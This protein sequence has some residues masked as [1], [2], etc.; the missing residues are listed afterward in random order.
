MSV[1]DTA[2]M[3]RA[4]QLAGRGRYS[5]SPNPR[6]ACIIVK[7]GAV[8]AE[9][10]HQRAGEGHAEAL[11]LQQAGTAAK[12]ATAYVTLEPCSH[13][14]RTPPCADALIA[15]GV[16]RVVVAC[17]DPNPR[18]AGTGIQRLLDAGIEVTES[19]L[20]APAQ[21][22]NA[23]FMR[24]IAGGL[25]RVHAKMASS[26]DGR[27]A[28]ASGESQWITG[29]DAR[30]DVQGLRASACAIVTGIDS[31]IQD[32]ARL[33]VRAEALNDGTPKPAGG[34][35]Q[36]LRVV[37]DSQLRLP[38]DCA[39]LQCEGAV[40]VA[41]VS[42]DRDRRQAL[43]SAG[44]EVLLL[45]AGDDGRVDALALLKALAE[46]ECN[47]V[48]LECGPRLMA[49]FFR[50]GLVDA[51]TLY[52]A[53]CFLGASGR[54]LVDFSIDAMADQWQMQIDD[55]RAVGKDWRIDFSPL[56]RGDH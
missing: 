33:N 3:S 30:N 23:G 28:M 40:L 14:G 29:A 26:L 55:M 4:L 17:R 2:W 56:T 34:W 52:M 13:F 22:L 43:E 5:T 20:E 16:A 21:A 48:L 39:L 19:V 53:P 9:A 25:P 24:R 45:P 51:A 54:P 46:R 35:R 38:A 41:T 7:D 11:A 36:P 50:R 8:I 15:A 1:G 32:Q 47:D 42:D 10:W 49:A 37:M 44:A 18:V 12:G 31:V 6:V 27:T